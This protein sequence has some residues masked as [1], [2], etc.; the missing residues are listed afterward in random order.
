MSLNSTQINWKNFGREGMKTRHSVNKVFDEP[1][2]M[3]RNP[4]LLVPSKRIA[5]MKPSICTRVMP[6]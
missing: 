2:V 5:A 3:K 4:G 6:E 1:I